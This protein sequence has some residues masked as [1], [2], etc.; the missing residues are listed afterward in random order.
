MQKKTKPTLKPNNRQLQ[1]TEPSQQLPHYKME[2]N[3]TIDIPYNTMYP[4]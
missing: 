3:E 2:H 1:Y 4:I